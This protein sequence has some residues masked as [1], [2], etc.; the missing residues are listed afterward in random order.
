[1][2]IEAKINQPVTV[3]FALYAPDGFTRLTGQAAIVTTEL[4]RTDASG[5]AREAA[6]ETVAVVELGPGPGEYVAL[7]TPTLERTYTL[8]IRH[9]ASSADLE[10]T[11]QVWTVTPSDIGAAVAG[12]S[13]IPL[14][15]SPVDT[16][17]IVEMRVRFVEMDGTPF[18]PSE[19][20]QVVITNHDTEQ[21]LFTIGAADI[22]RIALGEYRVFTPLVLASPVTLGDRWYYRAFA[23]DPER[24]RAFS[25]VVAAAVGADDLLVSVERLKRHEL[26]GCDLTDNDGVP[27]PLETF[28]EAIREATDE[29]AAEIDAT[30]RPTLVTEKHDYD[31]SKYQCFG[32]FQLDRVPVAEI[33]SVEMK[34]QGSGYNLVF[35][36][37][38]I[39]TIDPMFATFNLVPQTGTLEQF[40]VAQGGMG[41]GALMPVLRPGI[42]KWW[43]ALFEIQYRAGFDLGEVPERL[44]KAIALK[45]AIEILNIAGEMILG[46]GIASQSIAIGG[47]SQSV[48]TTSSATNAGHGAL[49]LQYERQLKKL[50]PSIRRQ[51]HGVGMSIA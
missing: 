26:K 33:I 27:L 25:L 24:N 28:E 29:L 7:F 32:W 6:T 20:R 44:Q 9:A 36:P 4:W 21:V 15:R 8:I 42:Y 12:H 23:G 3:Q 16:G 10:E 1:M 31:L 35:P 5:D 49:I 37:A 43:P 45:A 39:N 46:S 48:A 47:L 50:V 17:Q 14:D 41:G 11:I 34:F 38:W 19:L 30:L 2:A 18:D 40:L 51:F 22:E 13:V